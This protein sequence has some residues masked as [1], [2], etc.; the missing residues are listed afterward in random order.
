MQLFV[1]NQAGEY[2]APRFTRSALQSHPNVP[3]RLIRTISGLRVL[4]DARLVRWVRMG[5]VIEPA[6]TVVVLRDGPSGL[7]TLMCRRSVDVSFGGFWVFPGGRVETADTAP[8]EQSHDEGPARRAGAREVREEVGLDVPV[9][10][11]V[12]LSHWTSPDFIP[13]RFATWVFLAAAGDAAVATIDRGEIVASSW[14]E[15][16]EVIGRRDAGE[17]LVAPPTWV[18]LWWLT[19]H[20]TVRDALAA[21]AAAVPERFNPRRV[22]RPDGDV[23]L[24]CGDAGYETYD[25]DVPGPRHRLL[26]YPGGWV[27][28]R[29]V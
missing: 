10:S 17:M 14:L 5:A 2:A 19:Q 13:R 27:Y 20:A 8:N 15:P 1:R 23:L 26:T 29:T 12:A 7:Q 9:A 18:T 11:L 16:D 24:Q 21:A 25:V 3:E 4:G 22:Q 28:E 6:A